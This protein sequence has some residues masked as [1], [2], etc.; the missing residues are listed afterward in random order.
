[1]AELRFATRASALAR[2]QT[3]YVQHLLQSRWPGLRC[4]QQVMDTRGDQVL[5]KPLPEIGGKGLFTEELEHALLAGEVDAAVHS[6]KDLPVDNTP[7]LIIG[8]IPA[9]AA[10]SDVLLSASYPDLESLPQQAVVGTSSLR[11]QAQLLAQRPDLTARSIRGNVETRIR[12]MQEGLYDAIILAEA[13]VTRLG[14]QA[15]I[16]QRLPFSVM[17]PAPG[18]GALAVQCRAGDEDLLRLFSPLEDPQT[19]REVT[20]ER[21]FLQALGGGCSLPVGAFAQSQ[22]SELE[23]QVIVASP[24]GSRQIRLQSSGQDP[25]ELGRQ[26]AAEAL[27]CGAAEVLHV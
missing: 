9:R 3:D 21:S 15:E 5:D 16:R 2:W 22:G 25:D 12:K 24:D 10:A 19:R 27:R 8:L 23:L 1:M 4:I 11:R 7:G 14:R 17:L 18:Q 20:A 13:G 6:L 26:L